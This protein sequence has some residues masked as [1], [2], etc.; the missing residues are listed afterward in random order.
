MTSRL[1]KFLSQSGS[2]V[3]T[4]EVNED[5][6]YLALQIIVTMDQEFFTLLQRMIKNIWHAKPKN[7]RCII[8]CSEPGSITERA[9]YQEKCATIYL[10]TYKTLR[11]VEIILLGFQNYY[12]INK[13]QSLTQFWHNFGYI[14]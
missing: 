6:S 10:L 5:V 11:R 3:Y 2:L 1:E 12:T 4:Q 9:R 13:K 14:K 7:L 8:L